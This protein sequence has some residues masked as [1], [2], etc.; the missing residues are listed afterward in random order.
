MARS[1]TGNAANWLSTAA[2]PLNAFPVTM[3]CWFYPADLTSTANLMI[4]GNGNGGTGDYIG[5]IWDGGNA[6]ALRDNAVVVDGSGAGTSVATTTTVAAANTWNHACGT[7]TSNASRA[8]YLNGSGS[9]T[10]AG[11]VVKNS[12][13]MVNIGG[14]R[15]GASTFSPLNGRVAEAAIWS[16]VLDASEIASLA[17]GICPL[18]VRPSALA[19]YWPLM[20]WTGPEPDPW[21]SS[22]LTV[23]GTMAQADHGRILY[24]ARPPA[25]RF[26]KATPSVAATGSGSITLGNLSGVGT[27]GFAASSAGSVTLVGLGA[28]GAGSLTTAAAGSVSLAGWSIAAAGTATAPTIGTGAATLGGLVGDGRGSFTTSAVASVALGTM[29]CVGKT[30]KK[31]LAIY[32]EPFMDFAAYGAPDPFA[33]TSKYR[34]Q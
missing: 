4:L 33:A 8:V 18:L 3:A 29:T 21:R 34:D 30:P 16:V 2:A 20:G 15:V 23:N 22:A 13:A 32:P 25:W 1:N 5:L 17:A 28:S 9:A 27:A 11:S 31:L 10:N 12:W 19:G 14:Y 26:A 6:Y 7:Y 24:P